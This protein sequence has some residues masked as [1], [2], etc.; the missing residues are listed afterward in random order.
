VP[1]RGTEARRF[2]EGIVVATADTIRH[3]AAR[4]RL[5]FDR[6]PRQANRESVSID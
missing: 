3:E 1:R 2:R 4:R 5:L 6:S